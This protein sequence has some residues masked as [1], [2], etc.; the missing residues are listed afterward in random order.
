M[1]KPK[2]VS[3]YDKKHLPKEVTKD[4]TSPGTSGAR[5]TDGETFDRS[6]ANRVEPMPQTET[7]SEH[8][9]TIGMSG[10]EK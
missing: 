5:E 4:V 6:H 9:K 1:P 3:K 10:Q 8:E 2:T 7:G